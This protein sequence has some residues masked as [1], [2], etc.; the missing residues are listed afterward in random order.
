MV[1]KSDVLSAK[2]VVVDDRWGEESGMAKEWWK[3]EGLYVTESGRRAGKQVHPQII[4]LKS[5][6]QSQVWISVVTSETRCHF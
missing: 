4:Q 3:V 6:D 2:C 5:T 1:I